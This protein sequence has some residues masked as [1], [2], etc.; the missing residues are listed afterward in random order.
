MKR[1]GIYLSTLDHPDQKT[2]VVESGVRGW[3][4]P[5]HGHV[6]G[7]VLWVRSG[8]LMAQLFDPDSGQ[9]S[10]RPMAVAGAEAVGGVGALSQ[11]PVWAS[12]EGTLIFSGADDLFPL[13][14]FGRDGKAIET[15]S[16]GR[17]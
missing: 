17:S 14:W 15:V 7:H 10:G 3:Y 13:T 8:A 16:R 4:S 11:S 6:P 2:L 5:P 9:L 12:E 1:S